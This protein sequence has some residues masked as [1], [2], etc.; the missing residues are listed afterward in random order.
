MHICI[1]LSINVA[2]AM[3]RGSDSYEHILTYCSNAHV[4][5]GTDMVPEP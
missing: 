4:Y 2:G 3:Q 1:A 5:Y